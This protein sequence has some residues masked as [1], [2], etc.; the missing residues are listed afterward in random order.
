MAVM[1]FKNPLHRLTMAVETRFLSYLIQGYA[2]Y[3]VILPE[4]KFTFFL[5]LAVL[6]T[7]D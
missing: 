2:E 4:T 5:F 7:H 3:A 6:K 1:F